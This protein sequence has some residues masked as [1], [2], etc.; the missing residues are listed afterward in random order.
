M[1]STTA[2]T[3]ALQTT[4]SGEA[5]ITTAGTA[6]ALSPLSDF[7]FTIRSG[8]AEIIRY[9]G[10]S[11]D[12]VVPSV[13]NG[14]PVAIRPT[15]FNNMQGLNSVT[16]THTN[17]TSY[18]AFVAAQE[19]VPARAAWTE[20]GVHREEYLDQEWFTTTRW[21]VGV[22]YR[23][24]QDYRYVTR[25][26]EVPF[27][28]QHPAVQGSA[29]V[30]ARPASGL[31]ASMFR[32]TENVSVFVPAA[33]LGEYRNLFAASDVTV[34]A[35]TTGGGLF[36]ISVKTPPAKTEYIESQIL[37]PAGLVIELRSW[38][39][40]VSETASGFSLSQTAALNEV[41]NTR[42]IVTFADK[43]AWFDVKVVEDRFVKI[44][45]LTMPAKTSYYV[46]DQLNHAGLTL[47]ATRLSGHAET[48]TSGFNVY[49]GLRN[50]TNLNQSGNA[51]ITVELDGVTTTFE[52]FADD[53]AGISVLT[54][55]SKM[56]Y[57][58]GDQLNHA[59]LT[60]TATFLSGKTEVV[61]SGFEVFVG[62]RWSN[63]IFNQSGSTAVTVSLN[64]NFTTEFEVFVDDIAGISVLTPPSKTTFFE[65]DELIHTGLTLTVTYLSGKTQTVTSGFTAQI[66][67]CWS[68]SPRTVFCCGGT[69]PI[70]VKYEGHET[71][72][73]AEVTWLS[74]VSITL[75][76]NLDT[77]TGLSP[78]QGI[79][80]PIH[81][82]F[83]KVY[84]NG[85]VTAR[86]EKVGDI[87]AGGSYGNSIRIDEWPHTLTYSVTLKS[88]K[89][90][91]SG[92]HD[93]ILTVITMG[94]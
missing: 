16:F 90:Y 57:Y 6:A 7:E 3:A 22:G 23:V 26:R 62:S 33:S 50:N 68:L 72:Y 69:I 71:L 67:C 75:L 61:T 41:G 9:T 5:G 13:I 40:T 44:E 81:G 59:G 51:V 88:G 79:M 48:I 31:S 47:T 74:I 45:V 91:T 29:A 15:A 4:A 36:S 65:N 20:H 49:A 12:V 21:V 11:A 42:I 60:L 18:V 2:G 73:N 32:G 14:N 43:N 92:P 77:Q 89:T 27:T 78:G 82:E 24:V 17:P 39:G 30:P 28:I 54:M 46:G 34:A 58:V 55:P 35:A 10:S 63:N 87:F 93:F 64:E 25:I 38:D 83:E 19:A 86:W 56:S 1:P 52:V 70:A 84:N 94:W 53:V 85:D 80:L 76:S 66:N 8:V 37:D